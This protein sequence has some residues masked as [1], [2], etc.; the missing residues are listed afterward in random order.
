MTKEE[1]LAEIEICKTILKYLQK[2]HWSYNILL[3]PLR[4][5]YYE[6]RIR[7]LEKEVQR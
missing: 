7:K 1:K 2:P 4:I 5:W 3:R 6:S